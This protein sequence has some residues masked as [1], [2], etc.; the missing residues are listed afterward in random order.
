MVRPFICSAKLWLRNYPKICRKGL[1]NLELW[2][3]K[4][5]LEEVA[6]YIFL[7]G[8]NDSYSTFDCA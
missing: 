7:E 2:S 4:L 8:S 5:F 6:H 1:R 3:P